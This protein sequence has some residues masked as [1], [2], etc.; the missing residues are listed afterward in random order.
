M[1]IPRGTKRAV[2]LREV[3]ERFGVTFETVKCWWKRGHLLGR[4][5]EGHARTRVVV[6]VEVVDFYLRY[7]RLPTKL[8]LFQ[9]GAL[10]RDFLLELSGPDG[11]L[12][13]LSEEAAARGVVASAP[14]LPGPGVSKS[15]CAP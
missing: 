1:S 5:S 3:A 9:C 4:A 6:P 11:G 13:E 7:F 15:I 8:D 12:H 10:S 14:G 2:G